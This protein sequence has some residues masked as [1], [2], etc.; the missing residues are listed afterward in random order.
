V[1]QIGGYPLDHERAA[2]AMKKQA[3]QALAQF[4]EVEFNFDPDM[5]NEPYADV[6]VTRTYRVS[7]TMAKDILKEAL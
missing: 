6:I 5:K 7:D 2:E 4:L 1:D 3:D